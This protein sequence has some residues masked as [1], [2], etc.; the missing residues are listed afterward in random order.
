MGTVHGWRFCPRCRGELER[1]DGKVSCGACGFTS[2]ASSAPTASAL[3]VDERGRVLLARRAVEPDRGKWDIIGGFLEEG[4]H[5][6]DGL[7]REL[8]EE[9]GL[10]IEPLAYL[11]ATVDRYGEGDDAPAT[12]NLVWT[13]RVAGGDPEPADDVDEL[14]WFAPDELPPPE[15]CAF[16]HVAT[17]LAVWRQQ[18]A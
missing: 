13:A 3:P 12:L 6:L 7:R 17:V 16:E 15:E 5:P 8:A 2:Y 18:Q 11:T 9:T 1:E 14:R 4:E 10:E